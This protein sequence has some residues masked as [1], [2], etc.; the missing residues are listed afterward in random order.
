MATTFASQIGELATRAGTE[1]KTLHTKIGELTNLKT[2]DKTAIVAAVNEV[3]ASAASLSDTL[4]TLSTKLSTVESQSNTNK[5]DITTVKGSISTLE[6]S[7]AA[8]QE[9]IK[10]IQDQIASATNIDDTKSTTTT[11]YSSSKIDSDITAAKQAVKDDIL[12]GAGTAFDTLKEL[13]DLISTNKDAIDSL[14]TLAAGH[15][16]FDEAQTLS[17]TQKATACSNIGAAGAADVSSLTTRVTT[18]E[19]TATTNETNIT[20]LT[21]AVGDT[22]TDFVSLFETALNSSSS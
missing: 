12:G 21:T 11:T 22:S 3:K 1:C 5:G 17:D 9:S 6:S 16:K 8:V 19:G 15:V 2:T 13:A 18:V 10:T 14:K 4:N 7:V 20:N